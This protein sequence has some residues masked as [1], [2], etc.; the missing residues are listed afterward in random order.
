MDYNYIMISRFGGAGDLLMLEPTIEALYYKYAPAR[1][2][3]RTFHYYEWVLRDHPLIWKTVLDVFGCTRFGHLDSGV[4]ET[5]LKGT[6]ERPEKILHF[7]MS[8]AVENRRNMHGVDAF[9]AEADVTLLRRTPSVGHYNFPYNGNT[10]VQLRNAGDIR[11]LSESQLPMDL[12]G[13]ATFLRT[14]K[15]L[16]PEY[17]KNTIAGADLFIGSDSMGLHY[18]HAA[19]V[20]KIVG[21]YTEQFPHTIR[22]YP[23]VQVAYDTEEFAWKIKNAIEEPKYPSYLNEG[24]AI[25]HIKAKA[26]VHCRGSYGLDVGASAWQFP[27]AV[28]IHDETERYL[29]DNG[30]YDFVFS[31]HC[32]EHIPNWQEELQLWANTVK[33][34]GTVFIYVPH[35]RMEM[36]HPGSWWVGENHVWSPEPVSLVK[37]LN[38]NTCLKV[39]SYECYPDSYWSF[40]VI[41]R[42]VC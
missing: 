31:S 33:V 19:G 15:E 1:I 10:V 20:H 2:I 6:L 14:D 39:E 40:H 4:I 24:N 29:F 34:G 5:D 13:D 30:P 18:A 28:A 23:G 25:S 8:N 37:Y 32:L 41:A 36:W 27:G 16:D 7:N 22:A 21:L 12:L 26:L 38:E 42:R 9:A 17:I 3:L 35:P 11:D